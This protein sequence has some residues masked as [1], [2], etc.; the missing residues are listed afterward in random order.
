MNRNEGLRRLQTE[1]FDLCIIGGGASGAGCALDAALRGLKVVLVEKDDF[2]AGTSS[3]STKLI[4]G[5]VRYLEQA[6]RNFDFAQLRQVW[7]GLRERRFLLRNAPHL[8]HPQALLTPVRGWWEGLYYFIGLR[9]YDLL[10]GRGR[11]QGRKS[12]STRSRWLARKEMRRRMGGL[13]PDLHSAVLYYD[14]QMDD[15]R[16]CLALVQSA[17]EAGATAVNHLELLSFEK[18]DSGK[19]SGAQLRDLLSREAAG[20]RIRSRLFLNCTGPQAD[21]LR[22]LANPALP[23]RLRPSKGVHLVLSPG[24]LGSKADGLL[25]PKTPDGRVVFALPFQGRVL[26]GTTDDA[27]ADLRKEPVLESGEV[28]FL[29]ETLQPYLAEPLAKAAVTAGYGGLRPLLAPAPAALGNERR[30]TKRLL[31]DHLVEHDAGSNLLSLLGGKW[32]TYRLM[33]SD[34][35]DAACRLLDVGARSKTAR[36]RLVGAVGY[37]FPKLKKIAMANGLEADVAEH[38]TR[39]Y[40]S[41][42]PDLLALLKENA[43]WRERLVTAF[44]FL[45]AEVVYATRFEMACTLRDVLARRLRLEVLDWAATLAVIPETAALMGAELGWSAAEKQRQI[46]HYTGLLREFQQKAGL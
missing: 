30:S 34:A 23:G 40:G 7:H 17:V 11:L 3:K 28:D 12:K 35:V 33:A 45:K 24:A 27:Y 41:R 21:T 8:A 10:G 16:Y 44:P 42:V 36:H 19:I 25:I 37:A 5:G 13:R 43:A 6:F 22:Q 46:A 1:E 29:I 31:R 18:D 2:A 38:L 20:L 15:A 9:L 32:T 14:G 39:Q 4:H 26:L